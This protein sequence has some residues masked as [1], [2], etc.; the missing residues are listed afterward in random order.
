MARVTAL[1]RVTIMHEDADSEPTGN[2]PVGDDVTVEPVDP[3]TGLALVSVSFASVH[4]AGDTTASIMSGVTPQPAG[5]R[6]GTPPLWSQIQTTARY[7]GPVT[8]CMSWQDGQFLQESTIRVM[9]WRN[10]SW[11]DLTLSRDEGANR[12]C[13]RSDGLEYTVFLVVEEGFHFSGFLAPVEASPVR[14]LVKAGAAVPMKFS[15]GGDRGLDVL[16]EGSPI[17]WQMQC[18]TSAPIAMFTATASTGE[19]GLSYDSETDTYTYVWKT[20]K[21]WANSCRR[22]VL[23]LSDGTLAAANFSFSR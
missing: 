11:L 3:Q 22:F 21:A 13:A 18:D 9:Q 17:S 1:P 16:H 6:H 5:Y 19:S 14:N 8:V 15:L 20:E 23:T 4:L 2:T 12:I 7:S 10:G